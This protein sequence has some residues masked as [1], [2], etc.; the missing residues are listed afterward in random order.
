MPTANPIIRA[1]VGVV[2]EMVATEAMVRM[3]DIVMPT[4]RPAVIN[5]QSGGDQ[6]S[7]R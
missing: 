2:V 1:R 7:R 5:G 6:A 3:V 4:P